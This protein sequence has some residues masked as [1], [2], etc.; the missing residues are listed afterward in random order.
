MRHALAVSARNRKP[1]LRFAPRVAVRWRGYAAAGLILAVGVSTWSASSWMAMWALAT[2]EFAALKILTLRHGTAGASARR[3]ATYLALWPGM[4]SDAFLRRRLPPAEHPDFNELF[5]ALANW[6]LG[7]GLSGWAVTHTRS[8]DPFTVGWIGMGGIIFM[9]HF[10]LFHIVSWLWRRAG[11]FAPPIMRAPIV[12]RSL[13]ELWG[14]RWNLAFADSARRLLLRPLARRW[15]VRAAG[16]VVFLVSG[17]LHETVISLPARGGWGGPTLYFL[18][19]AVGIGVEKSDAGKRVGLGRGAR[20]WFWTFTVA[21]VPLP[22]LF[23]APFV[24]N[25]IVPFYRTLGAFIP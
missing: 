4:N 7:L 14:A 8:A 6:A 1:A 11:V 3:V 23:H 10:G 2:A 17:L 16:A 25:V 22:L 12:S 15:G 24:R 18:L 20:G 5:V 13:G 9:L 21:A 19:Q